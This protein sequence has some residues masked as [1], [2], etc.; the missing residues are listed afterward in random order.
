VGDA[1]R[2]APAVAHARVAARHRVHM[3]LA[4]PSRPQSTAT[5]TI[6]AVCQRMISPLRHSYAMTC[7]AMCGPSIVAGVAMPCCVAGV[8]RA[9]PPCW[10]DEFEQA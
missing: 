3:L 1:H 5:R 4:G 2:P 10:R 9:S 7:Y 6:D 8:A